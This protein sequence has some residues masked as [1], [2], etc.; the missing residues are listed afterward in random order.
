MRV[1]KKAEP[2]AIDP[3]RSRAAKKAWETMKAPHYAAAQTAR[4]SQE[5]LSVWAAS[6]GYHVTFLDAPSGRPRTGIVDALLIKIG[7]EDPDELEI[8]LVQL[9]GGGAGL[10]PEERN[11]IVMAVP[12]VSLGAAVA[13]W[14]RQVLTVDPLATAQPA[15]ETKKPARQR[16]RSQR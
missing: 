5:A 14:D 3:A 6:N 16:K 10:T 2:V 15:K 7:R 8:Q 9:K 11:R 13:M 4:L 1:E 12:K